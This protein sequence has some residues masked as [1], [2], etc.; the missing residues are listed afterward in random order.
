MRSCNLTKNVQNVA[1]ICQ[2]AS[3]QLGYS[4]IQNYMR[5]NLLDT[6]KENFEDIEVLEENDD[7]S[8]DDQEEDQVLLRQN[9][10]NSLKPSEITN[11]FWV[12]E[13][14]PE[15]RS[16]IDNYD[17]EKSGKWMMFFENALIDEKWQQL[18]NLYREGKLTGIHSM[19]VSTA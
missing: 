7:Y 19:K 14:D 13:W 15:I 6:W 1:R 5:E 17:H 18:V 16:R 11:N 3:R 2:M 12:Y 9:K 4:N 10:E 8:Q